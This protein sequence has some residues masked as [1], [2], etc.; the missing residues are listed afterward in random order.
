[1]S[2][3]RHF[4]NLVILIPLQVDKLEAVSDSELVDDD[5]D[6]ADAQDDLRQPDD[7]KPQDLENID[8]DEDLPEF[9][10]NSS[11]DQHLEQSEQSCRSCR[12]C[13]LT[14]ADPESLKSHEES[15][16][17]GKVVAGSKPSPSSFG[18]VVCWL[19]FEVR[20]V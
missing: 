3:I 20:S 1:M 10:A 16:N 12:D 2:L 7:D 13:D 18:C 5:D 17:H 19:G 4:T 6:A 8:S 15:E 14:F 11:E 9:D